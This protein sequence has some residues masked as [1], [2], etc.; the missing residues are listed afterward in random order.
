MAISLFSGA[1]GMD[2]G[3]VAAGWDVRAQI[4][5]DEDASNTLRANLIGEGHLVI[6]SRIEE[7]DPEALRRRLRIGKGQLG[8]LAGGPPCQPFTTSGRRQALGDRRVSSLFPAYLRFVEAFRPHALAIENVDGMLSAALRHRPLTHR[9]KDTAPLSDEETKGSFLR[10]F[11]SAIVELGYSVSWGVAEAADHGAPQMR[12]RALLLGVQGS[13]PCFLPTATYGR[14]GRPFRTVREALDGISELGPI[15]PLSERKRSVYRLVPPG[16]NWRDLPTEV[17]RDTM[18]AAFYAEGGRSGWWRRLAWDAPSPTILGM[19]DHS[20]T[21]LI[22]P[23]EVR[24]LSANEC[25]A[26][27]TFPVGMS[28]AGSSRSQYQQIGNAVPPVLGEAIGRHLLAFLGGA[29]PETPAP[30]AWRKA[31]ANRRIGTHGWAVPAGRSPQFHL[32]VKVRPDHIW[33]H[34]GVAA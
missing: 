34:G 16:G 3:L 14:D 10:W 15:Q 5:M 1:G 27:Q 7:V 2:L 25:A 18:G 23:D 24:C 9:G 33:A 20:S 17:Q 30:P 13:S 19:P 21:A 32:L 22:H 29:R 26:L 4:E 6:G 31:S 8:L 28:F 11:L 12:Q